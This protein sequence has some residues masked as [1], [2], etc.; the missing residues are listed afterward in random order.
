MRTQEAVAVEVETRDIFAESLAQAV[1]AVGSRR[2]VD[3]EGFR[4][5]VK[6][7]DVVGTGKHD[8]RDTM[9]ARGFVQID[10]AHDVGVENRVERA[11][12]RYAT[13]VHDRV[14]TLHRTRYRL[15]IAKV[16]QHD[17]LASLRRAI[18]GDPIGQAQYAAVG[19][20]ACA[21]FL[22]Q[23][24]G[25]AGHQDSFMALDRHSVD[26]F[27]CS[28]GIHALRAGHLQQVCYSRLIGRGCQ[29]YV[30]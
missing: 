11:F 9:L 29:S 22:A 21:H 2:A 20:Q 8:A 15:G 27:S 3:A 25:S 26:L 14:G 24:A 13:K 12:D 30:V 18:E 5:P 7:G 28:F 17:F 4:L 10:D 1:K 19:L 6:A 16:G 23:I